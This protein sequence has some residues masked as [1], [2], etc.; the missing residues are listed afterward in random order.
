MRHN[1][2]VLGVLTA[3]LGAG[4]AEAAPLRASYAHVVTPKAAS[5]VFLLDLVEERGRELGENSLAD[6]DLFPDL[7][8]GH[9]F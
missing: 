1:L 5:R 7:A 9:R 2:L 6:D 8:S 4:A 3:L